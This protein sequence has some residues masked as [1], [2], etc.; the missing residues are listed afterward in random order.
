[1]HYFLHKIVYLKVHLQK[2]LSAVYSFSKISIFI[3]SY[4]YVSYVT[5]MW[6]WNN[7]LIAISEIYVTLDHKISLKCQFFNI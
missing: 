4:V 1:M 3:G 2:P 6:Q 7:I 5:L